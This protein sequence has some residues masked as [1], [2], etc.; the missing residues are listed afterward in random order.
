[1]FSD[2]AF[3]GWYGV[4]N[5]ST[6]ALSGAAY[7]QA[8]FDEAIN[9]E[10]IDVD[11]A[12]DRVESHIERDGPYDALLGFSQ[13]SIMI[14]MLTMRRLER[15]ARGAGPPPSWRCNIIISGMAPRAPP[16]RPYPPPEVPALAHFPAVIAMGVQ[17]PFYDYSKRL[18]HI[19]GESVPWIDHPGGHEAP[20]SPE[21]NQQ[22]AAAVWEAMR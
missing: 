21:I 3:Y 11:A 7:R 8:L 5:D 9:F 22:L 16:Y 6:S 1:M 13:G 4:E 18:R 12:L 14:T 15:A 2:Q 19:Y 17:D 10:Y 20:S